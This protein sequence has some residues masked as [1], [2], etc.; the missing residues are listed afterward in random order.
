MSIQ[1]HLGS[2]D[3]EFNRRQKAARKNWIPATALGL[4]MSACGG[5][6]GTSDT[7]TLPEASSTTTTA[8]AATTGQVSTG[9]IYQSAEALVQA[10]DASGYPCEILEV[11]RPIDL[12]HPGLVGSLLCDSPEHELIVGVYE[13]EAE[14]SQG[15]L[16]WQFYGCLVEVDF[17][18]YAH[19]PNWLLF[20]NSNSILFE[21]TFETLA[22]ALGG[23]L[24]VTDCAELG[25]FLDE[26]GYDNLPAEGLREA[27]GET[28]FPDLAAELYPIGP[29]P[30]FGLAPGGWQTDGAVGFDGRLVA[31]GL[32]GVFLWDPPDP[33]TWEQLDFGG[34]LPTIYEVTATRFGLI[35][36]GFE[37]GPSIFRSEDGREWVTVARP[38]GGGVE[39]LADGPLGLVA[40]GGDGLWLSNDGVDWQSLA[41]DTF[42]GTPLDPPDN[43]VAWRIVGGSEGYVVV[44]NIVGLTESVSWFSPDGLEWS[45]TVGPTG[46]VEDLV[47]YDGTFV[48]LVGGD[49]PQEGI[50][51]SE[52]GVE[53]SRIADGSFAFLVVGDEVLLAVDDEGV[54]VALS[55]DGLAWSAETSTEGTFFVS[56][57]DDV[58][59]TDGVFY[60]L[61]SH[62]DRNFASIWTSVDGVNWELVAE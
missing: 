42:V 22:T 61:A 51:A 12:S 24:A 3:T 30:A 49:G 59:S 38:G 5:G 47:H 23:A 46:R 35:A 10:M 17:S 39:S 50:F 48:A 37:N 6:A 45:P 29:P 7:T 15:A 11:Y 20:P 57:V 40:V 53:W 9:V 1:T 4:V 34:G 36:L 14:R 26:F 18:T 31:F 41:L 19:G 52:D 27:L 33:S 25:D 60:M 44:A 13:S 58:V 2:A 28:D 43:A 21:S 8:T 56:V 62:W 55:E 54:D 16:Q 32:D